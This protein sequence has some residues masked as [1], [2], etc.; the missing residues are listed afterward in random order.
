MIE[1]RA[2]AIEEANVTR[3]HAISECTSSLTVDLFWTDNKKREMSFKNDFY[4]KGLVLRKR[5]NFATIRCSFLTY[6]LAYN[7]NNS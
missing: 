2:S 7:K 5:D 4:Q 3:R 6:P 1:K